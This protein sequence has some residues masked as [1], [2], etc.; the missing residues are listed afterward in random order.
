[1]LQGIA[2]GLH[3]DFLGWQHLQQGF[4]QGE[5]HLEH[6]FLQ[7][8]QDDLLRVNLGL[9]LGLHSTTL[10]FDLHG[11]GITHGAP[12]HEAAHL[13][14]GGVH[15]NISSFFARGAPFNL[16]I[17]SSNTP[18]RGLLTLLI[19]TAALSSALVGAWHWAPCI[20]HT[21]FGP[22]FMCETVADKSRSTLKGQGLPLGHLNASLML[23]D[24]PVLVALHVA[25]E[26]HGLSFVCCPV[27]VVDITCADAT[28]FLFLFEQK[29]PHFFILVCELVDEPLLVVGHLFEHFLLPKKYISGQLFV[30]F[31]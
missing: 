13:V 26:Q 10:H 4:L 21:I 24:L 11:I 12:P 28:L 25:G 20:G 19:L 22:S 16:L 3:G 8:E 17:T 18:R 1:M 9:H 14:R 23:T 5:Q 2:H 7:E 6:G 31:I 15:S 30:E 29:P 27:V